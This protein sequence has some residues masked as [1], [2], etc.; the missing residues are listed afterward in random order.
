M[1]SESVRV[2]LYAIFPRDN[3][4]EFSL[5]FADNCEKY[6]GFDE[7]GI[8]QFRGA[9]ERAII[10]ACAREYFEDLGQPVDF[11]KLIFL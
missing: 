4:L 8:R 2:L 11:I 5:I 6:Y 9:N 10:E 7:Y 3:R 1:H